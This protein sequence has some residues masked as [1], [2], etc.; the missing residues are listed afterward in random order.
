MAGDIREAT[1]AIVAVRDYLSQAR[2]EADA[3]SKVDRAGLAEL[4]LEPAA[5]SWINMAMAAATSFDRRQH[6]YMF[7]IIALYGCLERL[8]EAYVTAHIHYLNSTVPTYDALPKAVKLNHQKLTLSLLTRSLENRYHRQLDHKAMVDNLAS[9]F[10][11]TAP[12]RLNPE[13]FIY[14]ATNCTSKQLWEL[15]AQMGVPC[16]VDAAG[17][18]KAL[19]EHWA[20]THELGTDTLGA[21]EATLWLDRYVDDLVAR[22]NVLAHGGPVEELESVE[23]LEDRAGALVVLSEILSELFASA[24]ATSDIASGRAVSLG[25]PIGVFGNAI[26]AIRLSGIRVQTGDS[27]IAALRDGPIPFR[28]GNIVTIEVNHVRHEVVEPVD[29][30]DVA[31]AVTFHAKANYDYYLARTPA[32]AP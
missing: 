26:V 17:A 19:Y 21:R 4:P 28:R 10:Q 16:G 20:A 13:A 30:I 9:C 6:I 23:L 22:R 25:R 11:A 1:A 5:R 7:A 24:A 27:L 8:V 12:Y 31:F 3:L 2:R 18:T 29:N 15:L 32:I 14:R